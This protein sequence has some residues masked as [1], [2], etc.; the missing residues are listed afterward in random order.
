[1]TEFTFETDAQHAPYN[2][3]YLV[4]DR[5]YCYHRFDVDAAHDDG[6]VDPD[7]G[8]RDA[9]PDFG[10]RRRAVVAFYG[11]RCGRCAAQIDTGSGGDGEVAYLFSVADEDQ[12]SWALR[13][14][15]AVCEPCYDLLSTDC[16][17][18]IGGFGDAYRR[19]PQFPAWTGDPRVAVERL[20]LTGREVWFSDQLR[21]RVT[22]EEPT[23]ESVNADAAADACLAR[24]TPAAVA[25]AL[26]EALV[27]DERG[28]LSTA[29]RRL[30]DQ[31]ES[32]SE[33]E[34][35]AYERRAVDAETVVGGGFEPCIDLQRV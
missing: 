27:A 14:L 21:E 4:D 19:A 18:R 3:A 28:P 29:T 12:D 1:M 17:D 26:N 7:T 25:V 23:G 24:S 31:W 30:S 13:T 33:R 16:T 9:P 10:A 8:R 35:T 15:V 5:S 34:R 2:L 22:V 20:P 11:Y 32:L 6:V